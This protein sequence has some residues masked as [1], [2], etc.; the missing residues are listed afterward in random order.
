MAKDPAIGAGGLRAALAAG[1]G[2]AAHPIGIIVLLGGR[3]QVNG[4]T[5]AGHTV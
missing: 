2:S 5:R 1:L 4:C 3:D